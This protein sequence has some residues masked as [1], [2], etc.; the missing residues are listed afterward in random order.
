MNFNIG[1][2]ADFWVKTVDRDNNSYN[3]YVIGIVVEITGDTISL[4][5]R[6]SVTC[7]NLTDIVENDNEC[8]IPS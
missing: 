8:E 6:D 1:Q 5:Y 4:R 2:I 7:Y 3:K